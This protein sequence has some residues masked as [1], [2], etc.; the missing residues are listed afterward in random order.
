MESN[1]VSPVIKS[2]TSAKDFFF[3]IGA[4]ISLYISI[5]SF[6]NLW[7]EIINNAFPDRLDRYIDPYSFSLRLS[8]ASLVVLYPVYLMLIRM[9]RK[10]AERYPEK[11]ELGIKKFLVYLTLF[12]AGATIIID[13]ITLI[14]S[15]LGGDLTVRFI[16]KAVVVLVVALI[17]FGYYLYDLRAGTAVKIGIL[18][19]F[20]YGTLGIVLVS[21]VGSF[22]VIGSPFDQRNRRFD[23]RRINDLSNIQWQIINYWQTRGILPSKLSYLEDSIS[24]YKVPTD[25]VSQEPYL[26]DL[27]FD[28]QNTFKLCA[29]FEAQSP[30]KTYYAENENW[31]HEIG[32]TCFKRTIDPLLYP[33]RPKGF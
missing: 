4:I 28:E 16:L 2:R 19:G 20:R 10:D 17:V 25:P 8:V 22:F 24:G 3:Y 23:E 30:S 33:V 32:Q 7:F 15:F 13:L 9:I 5:G 27:S 26:Y 11:R 31:N 1:I 29:N 18:R 21:V 12:L 6:I 14:N